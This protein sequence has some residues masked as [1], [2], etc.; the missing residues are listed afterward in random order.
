MLSNIGAERSNTSQWTKNG[1]SLSLSRV[2]DKVKVTLANS[3]DPAVRAYSLRQR[4]RRGERRYYGRAVGEWRSQGVSA[5]S[6]SE[7]LFESRR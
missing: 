2:S 5:T 7:Q 3:F 1:G 6:S 4:Q